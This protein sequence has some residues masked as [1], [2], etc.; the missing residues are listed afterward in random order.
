MTPLVSII[1]PVYNP[2]DALHRCLESVLAQSYKKIE[3][4]AVNDGSTDGSGQVCEEYSAGDARLRY[5]SQQNAGVSAARNRGIAEAKGE[6][7]CFVDS[8]DS[9]NAN[10][11]ECMLEAVVES[12]ADIAIQGLKQFKNGELV[13]VERFEK[14]VVAVNKLSENLFDKIF[15]FCGPYCKLFHTSI[16]KERGVMFPTDM[17][18]GEDAVFYH[19]YLSYCHTIALLSETEYNYAVGNSDALSTR[20]LSPEKFW[21]NQHS[22]RSAYVNLK[23]A[24]G[25]KPTISATEQACKSAGV[26]G[27][28]C[29]IAKQG[30]DDRCMAEFL[31]TIVSDKSFDISTIPHSSLKQRITLMLVK[32]N[33]SFTRSLLKLLYK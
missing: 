20:T 29:S 24:Y 13:A 18:Y 22:R 26:A 30:L 28:L 3:V 4:I 12:Q 21:Q 16:I 23:N 6:Y 14:G 1:I 7:I 5:I 31:N 27:M 9:V 33:N 15:Y 17:A 25:L 11:I 32:T 8:D 19:K 2:G 10:Y